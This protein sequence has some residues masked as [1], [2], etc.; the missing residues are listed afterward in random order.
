MNDFYEKHPR[1]ISVN[2]YLEGLVNSRKALLTPP[3]FANTKVGDKATL[4]GGRF[5]G[6]RCG[7]SPTDAEELLIVD[8]TDTITATKGDYKI[9]RRQGADQIMSEEGIRPVPSKEFIFSIVKSMESNLLIAFLDSP[10]K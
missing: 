2:E 7:I 4:T 10:K 1:R 8:L 3:P 6:Y 5:L 9:M